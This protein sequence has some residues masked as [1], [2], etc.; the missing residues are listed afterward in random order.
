MQQSDPPLFIGQTTTPSVAQPPPERPPPPPED[1]SVFI[2]NLPTNAITDAL[3]TELLIQCGP[4]AGPVRLLRDAFGRPRGSAFAD[5]TSMASAQ[6]A[7][8]LLNGLSIGGRPLRI[9]L[10]RPTPAAA[11]APAESGTPLPAAPSDP[12]DRRGEGFDGGDRQAGRRLLRSCSRSRSRSP[13]P[14][15][16]R[17]SRSRSWSRPR[18]DRRS[19]SPRRER[20]VVVIRSR[21]RSP[22]R[23]LPRS[24]SPPPNRG[25]PDGHYRPRPR[26]YY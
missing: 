8:D 18:Y 17:R 16:K 23:R 15:W 19:Y 26:N 13:P 21:S 11:P 10:A 6:Y 7:I 22:R 24:R 12:I 2:G 25:D 4:L 3:L 5:F 14:R 1:P 9:N 20:P